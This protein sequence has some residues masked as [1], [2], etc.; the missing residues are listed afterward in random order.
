[1]SKKPSRLD[2]LESRQAALEMLVLFVIR[3]SEER[4]PGFV[5]ELK[6]DLLEATRR[7][8]ASPAVEAAMAMALD[9]PSGPEA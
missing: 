2:A 8:A 4:D 1:M 3:R 6:A 7:P 9:L 5:E